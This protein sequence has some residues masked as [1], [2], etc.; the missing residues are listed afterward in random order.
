MRSPTSQQ[1]ESLAHLIVIRYCAK[2]TIQTQKLIRHSIK[3]YG[4][5]IDAAIHKGDL[6][7]EAINKI[8]LAAAREKELEIRFQIIELGK[9]FV[10]VSAACEAALV[11]REDWLRALSVNESEW[12][13]DDMR[14]HGD[15]I[16]H[17]VSVLDLENSATKDDDIVHKPLKWC[18][19]MAMMNAMKANPQFGEFAH[20]A[21]NE[22]FNGAFGDYREPTIL[23]RLGVRNATS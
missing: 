14:K 6:K 1:K 18:C 13:T 21:C 5:I 22:L 12:H 11:P 3:L 2:K 9:A 20:N 7:A 17:V 4:E 23:E 19:T 8:D 16:G 10:H 15:T